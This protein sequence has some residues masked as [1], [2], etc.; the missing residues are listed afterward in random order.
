MNGKKILIYLIVLFVLATMIMG[1][2]K[3]QDSKSCEPSDVF[4]QIDV[5]IA[6][7]QQTR[8]NDDLTSALEDWTSF[9]ESSI[10][11]FS[12]CIPGLDV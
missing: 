10:G 5:A 6:D 7:Y 3:T 8:R 2:G 9:I 1:Y 11:I 12:V 4:Q